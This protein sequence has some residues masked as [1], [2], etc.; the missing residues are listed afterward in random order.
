M[1]FINLHTLPAGTHLY[2]V[3]ITTDPPG[4]V[5]SYEEMDFQLPDWYDADQVKLH[6]QPE[7][8]RE[9]LPGTRII[10]VAD[11][12]RGNGFMWAEEGMLA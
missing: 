2:T 7:I 11:Q 10:G 9:M 8:D 5:Q 3:F 1:F 6:A 4:A 12:S